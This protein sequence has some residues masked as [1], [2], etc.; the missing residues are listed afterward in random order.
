MASLSPDD[1]VII[2]EH[3]LD[4]SLDHLR[5]PLRDI[6][7]SYDTKSLQSEDTV[8]SPD[9]P[10]QKVIAR[11]LSTLQCHEVAFNLQS[12]ISNNNVAVDISKLFVLVHGAHYK[13]IYYQA[14]SRLVVKQA[15]DVDIWNA[16]LDIITALSRTPPPTNIPATF[17]GTPVTKSSASF[18][19]SE[20][21]RDIIDSAL[22]HEIKRCTFR[23]VGG[24]FEKYFQGRHWSRKYSETYMAIK[25]QYRG[26]RWIDFPD[27]P[28]G[29]AV[30]D[31]LSRFQDKYLTNL[32][33]IFYTTKSTSELT[34]G[35][36]RRQLDVFIKRRGIN[37]NS[38]HNWKDV[39]IV[40]E[41]KQS[42]KD[43]K[44]NLLQLARYV[45]DV[46][47][48][49]P[50]RRFVHG[51]ILHDTTMEL[52]VFDRS[53]PYSSGEFD[54]HEEPE[55]FIGAIAG[56][57]MMDDEELGLDTF[58]EVNDKGRF[59]SIR[60]DATG[61][62]NRM[63][64]DEAPFVKQRAIVC[65]GTTCFRSSDQRSVEKFS[66][67]SD[68]RPP[69][70]DQ[71]RRARDMGVEG[72]AKLIGYECIT[73]IN[74]LRS[75]LAFPPPHRFRDRTGST[76][77]SVSKGQD[78]SFPTVSSKRKRSGDKRGS[79]KKSKGSESETM[80]N[81]AVSLYEFD[82]RIYSNRIF[83]CLVITPAGRALSE[84]TQTQQSAKSH[85]SA[86]SAMVKLLTTFRDAIRAHRSLL[87]VANILHRD[88]SENNIIG[89]KPEET[90]GFAGVLIDLDLAKVLG[91]ARSGARHQTGTVQF[92]ALQVLK[93]IDHTY[94][95]DLESF[96]YVF[97]WIFARR[98]WENE[99]F[100]SAADRPERDVLK[101]WYT[102][103]FDDIAD[104][105]EYN[106]SEKKFEG[107]LD[108][109]PQAFN[110]VHDLCRTLRRLLFRDEKD[111]FVA[112][113]QGPP[114]ILY[115]PIL[116]A[117]DINILNITAMQE[118]A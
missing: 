111:V 85:S 49:Q 89:T 63:Q 15:P 59:V 104:R 48:A 40:G 36:A 62:E 83:G 8:E 20:Q 12:K 105:K 32:P 5:E 27:P 68:K 71:L 109:F 103:S 21:T 82:D 67:T 35:E 29:G 26:G 113:P 44:K 24:F 58:S 93:G 14:L 95:H 110:P 38:K 94:R 6:E 16:I 41:F 78:L 88:V 10:T 107:I 108:Q 102:G 31:W 70:A 19:G 90:G 60:L 115:D 117:F 52:W 33:G 65:R 112:T 96:F 87:L 43:L 57:A 46:F 55:K 79:Q 37:T 9:L 22:F 51:F 116:E 53:G 118:S 91:S 47:T 100:C 54:I 42:Q 45:R 13:Y 73:S 18:Q 98:V 106:M 25:E 4:T 64:L 11:L 76:T 1:R 86:L 84:F 3:P 75:G 39:R 77:S 72:I 69:E 92:M 30:W 23:N 99:F 28:E 17:D 97:I 101:W 61:K 50:I 114:G 66:W 2:A 7:Q 74:E 80:Q 56:Y 34:G 81:P